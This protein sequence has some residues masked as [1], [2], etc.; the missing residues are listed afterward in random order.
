[1]TVMD[2]PVAPDYAALGTLTNDFSIVAATVNGSGSQ[3]ANSV[4]VRALFKMGIPVSGKNLFPSNIKGLP[5]WF[6]IRLSK[7]GYTARQEIAPILVAMNLDTAFQ[8]VD[9]VPPGGIVIYP[10][11][12]DRRHLDFKRDD[13]MFYPI[14]TKSLAKEAGAP[15]GLTEYVANM[16]Y[17]G[18][19]AELLGIPMNYVQDAISYALGGKEKAIRMNLKV[20]ELAQAFVHDH[21]EPQNRFRVEPMDRTHGLVMMDGNAAAALGATFGGVHLIAWYPI[22]P[23]TSLVDAARGFLQEYRHDPETGEATYAVVQAED[24][25]A[26]IGMV[27]GAG[28]AGAR[29]MTSTSGPG[30]SLMAEYAGLGYFAE[31]PG[32]I[33][34]VQRVGPST[35]LPTRT[36]QGDLIFIYFLGHGDT[37]QV[38]L[39]PNGPKEC[40][41]CG[42]KAFDL[43]ER[44]QTPVFVLSDL[45]MGMN[46]WMSEPFEYPDRPIDRGKVLDVAALEQMKPG[47]WGRYK[48]VDGDGIPYRT[49]PGT[50]HPGA[51]Y[52]TR[53]TGHNENAVYSE[54]S[55]DWVQNMDRLHRKYDT[56]RELVPQPV[57]DERDGARIGIVAF[58]STDPTIVEARDWL[59]DRH[60]IETSYLR[61]RALPLGQAVFD[62][63]NRYNRIYVVENN[64]DGQLCQIMQL[65]MPER[66]AD[67]KSVAHLDG[68]PLSPRW[69]VGRIL[70]REEEA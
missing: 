24:E 48:D 64:H 12:W 66:A 11:D 9:N 58:G 1:M 36:S 43:A 56:A 29:A 49:L 4:I 67:L 26:A 31:I 20:V 3:T 39:L 17:V 62:F 59:R 42:W 28:W 51:G 35:G 34:D 19:L 7:D 61:V 18:A 47:E 22:T 10:E 23:S 8:D 15:T 53:G 69:V 52:F 32:V 45:D 55:D 70:E 2:Q 54:R 46:Q 27:F 65:E 30:I 63:V 68:L 60:G 25:L 50:P 41:E 6:Q 21:W 13:L 44:L 37:R 16:A 14:P 40:F 5:T 57:I 33:W 38:I